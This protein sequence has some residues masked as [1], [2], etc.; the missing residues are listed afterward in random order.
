[1]VLANTHKRGKCASLFHGVCMR[2]DYR[3]KET[4]S[5][6]GGLGFIIFLMIIG[7]LAAFVAIQPKAVAASRVY[8]TETVP[9]AKNI[10]QERD[11]L[12]RGR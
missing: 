10:R 7:L 9:V 5:S 2:T 4:R 12:A 8:V 6:G 3:F 1:M 11:Y